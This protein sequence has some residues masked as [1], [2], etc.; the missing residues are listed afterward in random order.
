MED[1]L[2]V[3]ESLRDP[4]RPLVCINEKPNRLLGEVREPLPMR[5]G[6]S[7]KMIQNMCEMVSVVSLFSLNPWRAF[8]IFQC[9]NIEPY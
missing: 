8:V 5:P 4:N 2:D 3:Y 9:W 6:D 1:I 7:K